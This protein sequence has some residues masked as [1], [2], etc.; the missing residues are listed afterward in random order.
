MV[1]YIFL[2]CPTQL[3]ITVELCDIN[4]RPSRPTSQPIFSVPVFPICV[5][6]IFV[7]YNSDAFPGMSI[8][9][10]FGNHFICIYLSGPCG[11]ACYTHNEGKCVINWSAFCNVICHDLALVWFKSD[12]QWFFN[13]ILCFFSVIFLGTPNI[14]YSTKD[15]KV[16]R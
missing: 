9:L 14:Q 13:M 7:L 3:A 2:L 16:V 1:L 4:C 10:L 8:L 11:N 15:E 5:G 6:P 12:L